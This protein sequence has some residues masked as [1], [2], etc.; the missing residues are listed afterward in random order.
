MKA[1][2]IA[3]AVVSSPVGEIEENV[4]RMQQWVDQAR[5]KGASLICF[6]ELNITGYTTHA[7][8]RRVARSISGEFRK[9]LAEMA[10]TARMVIL[11]GMAEI[12]SEGCIYATHL[13]MMPNGEVQ[14]Y[15]KLHLA[16]P[17]QHQLTSG[18]EVPIFKTA[19]IHAPYK[20][21][22]Q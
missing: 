3:A 7:D 15:R 12:D 14:R 2:R 9:H 6:P 17:E 4:D 16:P 20:V 22:Y 21:G 10:Q 11:A 5:L 1:L 19:G 8:I 13:V 18:D